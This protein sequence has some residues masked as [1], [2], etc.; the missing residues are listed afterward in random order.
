MRERRNDGSGLI[1]GFILGGV[2]GAG[3]ALLF[4][5]SKGKSLRGDLKRK[6][7]EWIDEAG[8]LIEEASGKVSGAAKELTKRTTRR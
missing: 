5:P 1:I 2:I 3:L 8:D 4:A 6:A 7:G